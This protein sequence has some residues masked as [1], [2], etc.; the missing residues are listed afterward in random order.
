MYNG[1]I[2][3]PDKCDANSVFAVPDILCMADTGK[4]EQARHRAE[5]CR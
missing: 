2:F 1:T 3:V 4:L 5:R